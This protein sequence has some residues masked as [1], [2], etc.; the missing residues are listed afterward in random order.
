MM[1]TRIRP[2]YIFLVAVLVTG[3]IATATAVSMLYLSL[4]AERNSYAIVQSAQALEY[5]QTCAERAIRTLRRDI[6]YMGGHTITLGTDASCTLSV[7]TG[8]GG[9]LGRAYA[10]M[11]GERG[12]RIVVNDVGRPH[13]DNI[14]AAR[15][16]VE[17]LRERGIEAIADDFM[18]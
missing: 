9:G 2:G 4:A 15:S 13:G 16:V 7:I 3:A 6:T 10:H 8:A 12:C 14:P 17:E 18:A 5:A 11:L 1:S